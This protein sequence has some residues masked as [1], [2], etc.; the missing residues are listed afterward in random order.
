MAFALTPGQPLGPGV[1]DYTQDAASELFKSATKSLYGKEETLYDGSSKRLASFLFL[2]KTRGDSFGWNEN[3]ILEIDVAPIPG[4]VAPVYQNLID[5]Y[6][7]I[8]VDQVRAHA[9]VYIAGNNRAAQDSQMLYQA[10]LK[11]IDENSITKLRNKQNEYHVG[12]R[13]CGE[14][15]LRVII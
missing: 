14:L 12:T 15:L 5:N 13:A 11:S 8:T 2:I 3:G 10:I 7:R 1:L 9:T 6:A 4:G